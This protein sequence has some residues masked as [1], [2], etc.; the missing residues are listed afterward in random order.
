MVLDPAGDAVD[1]GTVA[2]R[3]HHRVER[4]GPQQL[5]ADGAG[6]LGD[7]RLIAVG[8]KPGVPTALRPRPGGV[9]GAITVAIG[10]PHLGAQRP[11]PGRL[12][13]VDVGREEHLHRD[14]ATAAGVRHGLAEVPAGRA[15]DPAA[16]LQLFGEG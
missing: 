6:T 11:D 3:D 2:H 15:D 7:G 16:G 14:A 5:D 10:H 12:D 4:A 8:D 9:I 1:Q 13:R